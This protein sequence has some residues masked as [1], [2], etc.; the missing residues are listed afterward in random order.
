MTYDEESNRLTKNLHYLVDPDISAL[1]HYSRYLL[2]DFR[3]GLAKLQA[4]GRTPCC[5]R[6][7]TSSTRSPGPMTSGSGTPSPSAAWRSI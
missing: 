4:L 1:S 7:L 6:I 5:P 2:A 3:Y